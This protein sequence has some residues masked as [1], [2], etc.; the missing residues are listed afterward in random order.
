VDV[1]FG[2]DWLDLDLSRIA[3]HFYSSPDP[4]FAEDHPPKDSFLGKSLYF[5]GNSWLTKIQE[6]SPCQRC[7]VTLNFI[8][9]IPK[10]QVFHVFSLESPTKSPK[11]P[12]KS[13]NFGHVAFPRH[14]G[15]VLEALAHGMLA[16]FQR[17]YALLQ[18]SRL[19]K[20]RGLGLNRDF[21]G[22]L[23]GLYNG[24]INKYK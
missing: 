9:E 21:M 6:E 17:Q 5:S 24:M 12:A 13:S 8:T 10:A 2:L 16:A 1:D 11:I 23:H 15:A 3:S 22:F 20:S 4:S 18:A 7:S 14:H 19:E